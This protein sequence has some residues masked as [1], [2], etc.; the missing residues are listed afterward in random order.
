MKIDFRKG[1]A[2]PGGTDLDR[3]LVERYALF[4]TYRN[5]L[6]SYRIHHLPWPLKT[7]HIDQLQF[8]PSV[9]TLPLKLTNGPALAH[10]SDGVRI[11]SW[12][13]LKV[14][15]RPSPHS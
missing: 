15:D 12:P 7:L 2:I 11:L 9:D 5:S 6:W 3:W 4:E 13:R 1:N 14:S 8:V 10:W